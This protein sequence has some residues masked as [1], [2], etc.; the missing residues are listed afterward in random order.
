MSKFTP[1][2]IR[3]KTKHCTKEQ[4]IQGLIISLRRPEFQS[5]NEDLLHRI[6]MRLSKNDLYDDIEATYVMGKRNV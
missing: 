1:L 3:K 5:Y 2:E 6:M 4:L